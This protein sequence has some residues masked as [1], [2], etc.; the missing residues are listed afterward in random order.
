M[1]RV[2]ISKKR[3]STSL[4]LKQVKQSVDRLNQN[5]ACPQGKAVQF[6]FFSASEYWYVGFNEKRNLIKRL[7][8][9]SV[10]K[11]VNSLSSFT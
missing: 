4:S 9:D 11:L 2:D 5:I 1:T 10:R 8:K 3:E 7:K 6:F